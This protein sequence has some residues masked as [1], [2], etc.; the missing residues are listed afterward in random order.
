MF[1]KPYKKINFQKLKK[2]LFQNAGPPGAPDANVL[3]I[4]NPVNSTV[5]VVEGAL[6]NEKEM[7]VVPA[8]L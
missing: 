5:A 3:V 2:N 1:H 6:G 8:L 4:S 7:T